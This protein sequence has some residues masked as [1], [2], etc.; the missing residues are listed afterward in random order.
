MF[1]EAVSR[2]TLQALDLVVHSRAMPPHTYLAGGTAIAL[3]LGHRHSYDLD[4]FVNKRFD[5]KDTVRKLKKIKEYRLEKM[6]WQTVLGY[7]ENIQCTLFFYQYPLL[8][9]AHEFQGCKIADLKDLAAMKIA[10]LSDRGVKRDF[11]DLYFIIRAGGIGLK[12]ALELY[13][14]KFRVL[15]ANRLHIL[16]SLTYFADAE[17]QRMPR[18]IKGVS[19]QEVK[20]FLEKETKKLII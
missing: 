14:N 10:A 11:V 5:A 6:S 4:F 17:N 15:E 3:H 13:G 1:K 2:K 18:M 19:W 7:I 8:I 20:K 16:R 9:N 12:E